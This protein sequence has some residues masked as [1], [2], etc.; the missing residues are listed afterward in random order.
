MDS[1]GELAK[2]GLFVIIASALLIA[3]VF[4]LS[5]AL[6]GNLT[7]YRTYFTNAGG[8]SPGAEVRYEGGPRIGRIKKVVPDPKDPTRM[9]IDFAVDPDTPVYD[10]KGTIAKIESTSALGENYL[11]LHSVVS[12]GP[13]APPNAV[14]PSKEYV[15]IAD[16]FADIGDMVT[17]L[18]PSAQTLIV[19]LNA[20]VVEMKDTLARVNKLLDEENQANIKDSIR[21][22][23]GILAENR[24]AIRSSIRHIDEITTKLSPLLDN[25]KVTEA[26][27]NDLIDHLDK[28][29][30]DPKIQQSLDKLRSSLVKFDEVM[31]RT[32]NLLD[33]N[34]EN[35]DEII[36]NLRAVSDNMREFTETIKTRPYTLI[37]ASSPKPHEPGSASK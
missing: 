5:G 12:S 33:A 29:V 31:T 23:R 3:T 7:P 17:R 16:T 26:K 10:N 30:T 21:Q 9:E 8:L 13:K 37:R 15:S 14:I 19:N 36:D 18:G 28:V 11:G 6:S 4:Y 35:I 25:F 20:R 24:P 1:K 27:A 34:S 22:I 32:N 2:V